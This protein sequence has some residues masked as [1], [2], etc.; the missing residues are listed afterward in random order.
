VVIKS[1]LL[2]VLTKVNGLTGNKEFNLE[3]SHM[4]NIY[5]FDVL[6]QIIDFVVYQANCFL[7]LE[8]QVSSDTS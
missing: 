8:D 4:P 3:G 1:L 2:L 5:F 6:G 7:K